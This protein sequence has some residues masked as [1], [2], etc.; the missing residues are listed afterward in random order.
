[1]KLA[2]RIEKHKSQSKFLCGTISLKNHKIFIKIEKKKCE[3]IGVN[4]VTITP[5]AITTWMTFWF[6]ACINIV[7]PINTCTDVHHLEHKF[8]T[9]L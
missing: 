6:S 2:V 5:P 7:V 8:M 3:Q 1:M 4:P 9:R